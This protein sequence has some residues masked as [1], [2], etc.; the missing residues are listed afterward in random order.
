[1]IENHFD[2]MDMVVLNLDWQN[3]ILTVL[4]EENHLLRRFGQI[5]IVNLESGQIMEFMR[6]HADEIWVLLDGQAS[7]QM[8]DQRTD[9]PSFE[10][11]VEI[12]LNE[13]H[14]KAILVPFGVTS[15]VSA[16]GTASFL[17]ISTHQELPDSDDHTLIV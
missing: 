5:D 16:N 1:M 7:L 3:G 2:I 6:R 14:P 9:S 8:K 17:R 12:E 10:A 4:Q 15:R 13:K 11:L